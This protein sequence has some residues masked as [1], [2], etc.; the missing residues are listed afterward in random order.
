VATDVASRGLDIHDVDVIIH[1]GCRNVDS[2]VHR[3][4]RTG[5]AGKSG[6]NF[7]IAKRQELA[8]FNKFAKDLNI[9]IEIGSSLIDQSTEKE[10][11]N[12]NWITDQATK[13][14]EKEPNDKEVDSLLAEFFKQNKDDQ[15][16]ILRLLLNERV[17][18]FKKRVW[19]L[20]KESLISGRDKMQTY[21][22]K[23]PSFQI[24]ELLRESRVFFLSKRTQTGE[25]IMFELFEDRV[26]MKQQLQELSK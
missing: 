18:S 26:E 24:K 15:T 25:N 7:V 12:L 8:M 2:F 16:S 10:V 20:K 6:L 11:L 14:Y 4:G 21:L 9:E 3:S 5:R 19:D 17:N 13:H 23:S 1:L 22:I